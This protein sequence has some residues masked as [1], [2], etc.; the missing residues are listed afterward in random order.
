MTYKAAGASNRNLRNVNSA[1]YYVSN[2]ETLLKINQTQIVGRYPN[3]E[4]ATEALRGIL[5]KLGVKDTLSRL[6]KIP[7]NIVYLDN[8]ITRNTQ[9]GNLIGDFYTQVLGPT[10]PTPTFGIVDLSNP[11]FVELRTVAATTV[12]RA[13]MINEN[14]QYA[15]ITPDSYSSATTN[16]AVY[17]ATV[18]VSSFDSVNA[19]I[20]HCTCGFFTAHNVL[21]PPTP[22][23]LEKFVGFRPTANNTWACSVFQK[24]GSLFVERYNVDTKARISEQQKLTTVLYKNGQAAT[25]MINNSPVAGTTALSLS[26]TNLLFLEGEDVYP[27]SAYIGCE[28]KQRAVSAIPQRLEIYNSTFRST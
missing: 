21:T 5:I 3:I 1:T 10:I 23:Q 18:R 22:L 26:L 12:T 16:L 15:G 28:V 4:D 9:S 13:R 2:N 25:W 17:D 14:D 11:L 8:L 24:N 20:Q 6:L 27:N 7:T 19:D